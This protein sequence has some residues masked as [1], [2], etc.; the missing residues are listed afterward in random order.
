MNKT[1]IGRIG[2]KAISETIY[3][4]KSDIPEQELTAKRNI[5]AKF[6]ALGYNHKDITFI[7]SAY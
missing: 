7:D 5:R 3:N 4:Y 6:E 2:E 1:I